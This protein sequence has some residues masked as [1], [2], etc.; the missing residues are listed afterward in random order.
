MSY[1]VQGMGRVGFEIGNGVVAG[2]DSRLICKI[3]YEA[4]LVVW[5]PSLYE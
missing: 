4:K 5:S 1:F 3:R 2:L